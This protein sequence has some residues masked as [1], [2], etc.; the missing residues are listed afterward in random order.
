MKKY[1]VTMLLLFGIMTGSLIIC[2][3]TKEKQELNASSKI[4]MTGNGWSYLGL[5]TC[6][7]SDREWFC[8][9]NIWKKD[10]IYY[11]VQGN[12]SPNWSETTNRPDNTSCETGKC[13]RDKNGKLY[14][15]YNTRYYYVKL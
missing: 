10:G 4:E 12:C 6:Y 1:Y 11:W 9:F 13:Q 2:S 15:K 14:I 7:T 3:F 5:Y 8:G